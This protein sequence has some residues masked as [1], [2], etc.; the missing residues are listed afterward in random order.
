MTRGTLSMHTQSTPDFVRIRVLAQACGGDAAAQPS[1]LQVAVF[2]S[3]PRGLPEGIDPVV[4]AMFGYADTR[5]W[6]TS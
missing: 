5:R 1:R 4:N 6:S 2:G 3:G